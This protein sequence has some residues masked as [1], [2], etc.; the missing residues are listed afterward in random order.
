MPATQREYHFV[1]LFTMAKE[2]SE[3]VQTLENSR[4][5]FN[6][7]AGGISE[8]Q[9]SV[10][11]EPGRWS[12]L[13]CVEHVTIVEERFLSRLEGAGQTATPPAD[14]QREADLAAR[15]TNRAERAQAPEPVRP[16][17]RFSS[18][19]EALDGFNAARTRT[20]QFAEGQ[21]NAVYSLASE[22]PRF[23]PLNGAELLIIMA[24]HAR[25]HAAQ[26]REVRAALGTR[27][28]SR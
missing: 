13:E 19:A 18:L 7:A 6:A 24:G 14:K 15:V 20:V 3:L 10:R 9:A 26:I 21:G 22:H 25:R 28:A 17:G 1:R 12:V 5:E 4:E 11:A 27:A 23:G 8:L 2:R 16:S